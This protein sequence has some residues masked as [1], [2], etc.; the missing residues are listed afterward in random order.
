MDESTIEFTSRDGIAVHTYRW[1]PEESPRAV[2][3]VQHG[4]AEHA[5]RY[6]RFAEALTDAGYLVY[7]PDARGSGRTAQGAYGS[8]GAD[9]WPGWVN[10]VALLR[11]R[12]SEEH[13]DLPVVL[14]GH[15]MGSFA[16]Q[17]YLLDHSADVDAVV[18]SGSTEVEW[19]VPVLDADE[20]A[21]LSAFNEPFEHRTGFEWLSRDE[22][23]VDAYVADPACGWE[24]PPLPGIGSLAAA[25]DPDRVAAVRD[26]LPMLIVSGDADPLAQGGATVELLAQRYRDA[27]LGDVEVRLY[28]GGRHE[29]LNETNRD[30]VTDDILAFLDRVTAG[31]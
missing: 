7:A 22:A 8:W 9:G 11:E 19:L 17:H 1:A 5:A 28:P 15:S 12:I 2:V 23:E 10:D 26:D 3:Q 24:A 20:P 27:G 18:L 16:T 13:P 29:L 30:E 4:L 31:E 14:F 25:A 21:D 6:R